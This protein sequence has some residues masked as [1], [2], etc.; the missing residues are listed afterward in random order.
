[1]SKTALTVHP[2]ETRLNK[3][4]VQGPDLIPWPIPGRH[5]PTPES[6]SPAWTCLGCFRGVRFGCS[7][8]DEPGGSSSGVRTFN[9]TAAYGRG[10]NNDT[11][12]SQYLARSLKGSVLGELGERD[13]L[14][15]WSEVLEVEKPTLRAMQTGDLQGS[16]AM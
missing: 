11:V 1:M 14:E 4:W 3:G 15:M 13:R 10:Y 12:D 16:K 6:G 5:G 9:R 7:K 8:H 2:S